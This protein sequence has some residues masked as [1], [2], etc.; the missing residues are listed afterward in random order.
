MDR[1]ESMNILLIAVETGSL[2]AAGRRLGMPLPTVSRKVSELETHLKARLLN[3][4]TRQL[5]LTDPGRAYVEACKRI[6]EDVQEAERAAAGEYSAPKGELILTAPVVL[7]RLHVLPVVT[8][9]LTAYPEVGVR[10]VLGDRV[11]NLMEDHID[12]AVRIGKLPDSRLIATRVGATQRVVCGS[13]D[14]FAAHG[15]P[16]SPA[17]LGM[18]ECIVFETLASANAWEFTVDG[19]TVLMPIRARLIVN[20]A[21]AAIDAAT[22]G[23]GITRVLSYQIE[24]AKRSGLLAETLCE[25]GSAPDPVSL[26]YTGQ[27]R[28]PQKLRAFLDFAAPRLRERL[29]TL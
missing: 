27:A 19:K 21:E 7:G 12:V 14:Y 6:L 4:T 13:P 20:T 8:E 16:S 17:D 18:H 2:S 9:F 28:R 3:R 29:A 10:L 26:V 11:A 24:A 1:L 15:N 25:F 22:A 5:T 23:F